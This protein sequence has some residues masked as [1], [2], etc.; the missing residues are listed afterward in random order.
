MP[1]YNPPNPHDAT[2]TTTLNRVRVKLFAN[3]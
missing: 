2:Q 1:F 3:F